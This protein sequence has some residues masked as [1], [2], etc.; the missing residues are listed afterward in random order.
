MIDSFIFCLYFHAEVIDIQNED[1]KFLNTDRSEGE[2]NF[3]NS[4]GT[5]FEIGNGGNCFC[6]RDL[7]E[8]D[9]RKIYKNKPLFSA[10]NCPLPNNEKTY[11]LFTENLNKAM[12]EYNLDTCLRKAHFLA[13]IQIESDKLNTTKEYASGWDYDH[14]THYEY[15]LKYQQTKQEK[16]RRGYNRYKECIKHGNNVK[17]YGPKYKGRGLL[18]LT[19]KDT[20]ESYFEYIEKDFI[21]DPEIVARNLYYTCNSSTWYW[22]YHSQWG[23]LNN[24]A[25]RDDV[26]FINIGV[27]GGFNHFEERID[28]V[29]MILNFMKVSDN[30]E[31][32]KKL[33]KKIG[34]YSYETSNIKEYKYG[35][36]HKQSFTKYDDK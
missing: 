9:I 10:N 26:Y 27:N 31:K 1:V 35:R 20:Y 4:E 34:K 29:K 18:Q 7:T 3:S 19:W 36:S 17:G 28:M 6:N 25:D 16:Y 30:C 11:K 12:K 14:S 2:R 13:Q 33:N 5:Y 22:K 23:D 32:A 21:D 24:A 15:Y 8:E